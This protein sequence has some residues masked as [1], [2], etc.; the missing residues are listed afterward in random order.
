M[1]ASMVVSSSFTQSTVAGIPDTARLVA[2]GSTT[3]SVT[4][5]EEVPSAL[6]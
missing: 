3:V 6:I 1:V 2:A 5:D 4:C